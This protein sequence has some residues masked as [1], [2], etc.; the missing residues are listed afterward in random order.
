VKVKLGWWGGQD[1]VVDRQLGRRDRD[2]ILPELGHVG[3]DKLRRSHVQR[4]WP[5]S[6]ASA[7]PAQHLGR[8]RRALRLAASAQRHGRPHR[9]FKMPKSR[10][11]RQVPLFARL[12]RPSPGTG[13]LYREG[14]TDLYRVGGTGEAALE[15]GRPD[16]RPLLRG[17]VRGVLGARGSDPSACMRRATAS[18]S[19]LCAPVT[20]SKQGMSG[21]PR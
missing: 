20:T 13:D 3:V 8:A 15:V 9:G 17:E 5:G 14:G 11:P 10:K 19:R 6:A 18:S 16:A 12:F 7:P 1:P 4:W 2:W 21:R